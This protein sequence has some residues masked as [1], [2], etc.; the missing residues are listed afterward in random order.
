MISF[1]SQ[2]T[3]KVLQYFFINR[4]ESRYVNDLA[5]ILMVDPGNLDRKLKE[6]E[7]ERILTHA[8]QGNQKYYQLNLQYTLLCEM[9]TLFEAQYGLPQKI[10]HCLSV[11]S[12]IQY[13]YIFGSFAKKLRF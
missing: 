2:I 7:Q 6:L 9:Q 12:N 10:A 11:F 1:R 8:T 4:K 3:Q 13:G 5:R